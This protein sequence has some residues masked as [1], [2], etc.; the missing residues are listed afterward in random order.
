MIRFLQVVSC[1]AVK[2][3]ADEFAARDIGKRQFSLLSMAFG[4]LQ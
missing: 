1:D 4:F 3:S 2:L